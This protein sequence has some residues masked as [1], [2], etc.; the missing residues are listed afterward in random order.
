[1]RLRMFGLACLAALL[2]FTIP[3]PATAQ[4]SVSVDFRGGIGIP[5][6]ALKDVEKIGPAFTV[7]LDIG[8]M[9]RIALRASGGAEIYSGTGLSTGVTGPNMTL[10]HFN[11]GLL[12]HLTPPESPSRFTA[13]VNV[14][15]GVTIL[16][17]N[18]RPY[19]VIE[20]GTA[21][22]VIIDYSN[23]YPA[24]NA[25]VTLG[26]ALSSQAEAFVSGQGNLTFVK[27][28]QDILNLA[29]IAP[30]ASALN[31]MFSFPVTV[32]LKFHFQP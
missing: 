24:V 25:G 10:T 12:F 23:L 2:T 27:Q 11:G 1:M 26:Y 21:G 28:T 13:D 32:G 8:I 4:Q 30:E 15:G 16:T 5:T 14:G 29:L 6:G 17:S 20:N 9:P 18:R 22:T 7:G 3:R 19:S 31:K